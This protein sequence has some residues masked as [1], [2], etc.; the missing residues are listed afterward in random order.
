MIFSLYQKINLQSSLKALTWPGGFA[1]AITPVI[2]DINRDGQLDFA[3]HLNQGL[4][5]DKLGSVTNAPTYNNLYLFISQ[6]DGTYKDSTNQYLSSNSNSVLTGTSRKVSIADLNN[7]GRYDWVYAL[8]REDGRSGNPPENSASRAVALVSNIDGTYSTITFSNENF[9]HTVYIDRYLNKN[10]TVIIAGY[11]SGPFYGGDDKGYKLGGGFGY[12]W[13]QLSQSFIN[14]VNVPVNSNTGLTLL[15]EGNKAVILTVANS[16]NYERQGVGAFAKNGSDWTLIDLN[17]PYSSKMVDFVS[18]SNDKTKT[19]LSVIEPGIVGSG[20]YYESMQITLHPGDFSTAV[21]KFSAAVL[22]NMRSDGYYYQNDGLPYQKLDFFRVKNSK[23][24]KLPVKIIGEDRFI[25]SNF[26][27]VIDFNGD[28]LQDVV[29]YTYSNGGQPRVYLNTGG[30]IFVNVDPKIFPTAP[31]SWGGSASS[32]FTDINLDGI[33]D[34]FYAPMNGFSFDDSS[35]TG[36]LIYKGD[37]IYDSNS[38]STDLVIDDRLNTTVINTFSGADVVHD[39]GATSENCLINTGYGIDRLIYSNSFHGYK[40]KFN[41]KDFSYN[42]KSDDVSDILV[43]VERLVFSDRSIAIDLNGN[44][45]TT[46]K[47]L[48]AVFGKESVSNKN[49]VGIG[50]HFLDAGWT[51]DNLAALALDA[52]GAKTNDQIVSLL[53]TNVIGTKPTAADKQPFIA[54]LENGMTAGALANLAADT[55]FNTTNINLVGLA[56]TGI[57]YLPIN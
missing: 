49:Y 51:Y 52:A 32:K 3:F 47:I 53:W 48:G 21:F 7:D 11:I 17:Y 44:A 50:L 20:V 26:I 25:N 10:P 57:E 27:D 6:P 41:E 1:G 23:V 37:K 4:S 45:G 16:S 29:N 14:K 42:V 9:Y 12:T 8:N 13:D 56:Q 2:T 38:I 46:A 5:P 31:T 33:L 15:D 24:E 40:V 34:L 54:L 35:Q 19:L 43:N 39:V 36:W 22:P 55:S 18:Y 28:G 30:N